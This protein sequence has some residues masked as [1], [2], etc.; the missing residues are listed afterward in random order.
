MNREEMIEQVALAIWKTRV[1]PYGRPNPW[2][3]ETESLQQSI[4]RE[5]EAAFTVSV[6]TL[7]DEVRRI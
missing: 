7:L 4:R 1:A 2:A 3:K 6:N 5:A